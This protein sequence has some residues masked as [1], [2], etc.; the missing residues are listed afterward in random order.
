MASRLL[1]RARKVNWKNNK[2]KVIAVFLSATFLT[3]IIGTFVS[4]FGSMIEI[5]V[6]PKERSFPLPIYINPNGT[7]GFV[8]QPDIAIVLNFSYPKDTLTIGQ[9][10]EIGGLCFLNGEVADNISRITLTFQNLMKYESIDSDIPKQA[11]L[12]FINSNDSRGLAFAENGQLVYKLND[13]TTAKWFIEGSYKPII[14]IFYEN[15]TTST[16]MI[17]DVVL[18]VYPKEQLTQNETNKVTVILSVAV[19]LLGII[20]VLTLAY[21]LWDYGSDKCNYLVQDV[22]GN[23]EVENREGKEKETVPSNDIKAVA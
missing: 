7:R 9:L 13:N 1:S 3:L 15:D 18:Q 4:T 11:F 8:D 19:L 16:L 10:V 14:G 6:L 20:E 5:A 17:N 12:N 22:P 21:Y 2:R 23:K